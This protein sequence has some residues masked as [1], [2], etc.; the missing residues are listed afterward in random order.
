MNIKMKKPLAVAIGAAF[1][2]TAATSVLADSSPFTAKPLVSGYQQ[3]SKTELE[4][5]CG[6]GKCGEAKAH[7]VKKSLKEGKC[8][9]GQC[10]EA[11][12]AKKAKLKET[13]S[14]VK[15]A[16]VK[17]AEDEGKCGEGKCGGM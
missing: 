17:K 8:G 6:E 5:K 1:L 13:E 9:E 11:K 10:D 4:G 7:E 3:V 2:A 15:K 16:A 12:K 14:E